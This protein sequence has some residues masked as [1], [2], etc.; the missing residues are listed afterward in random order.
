MLYGA[1]SVLYFRGVFDGAPE[2]VNDEPVV[3]AEEPAVAATGR[4]RP[5]RGRAASGPSRSAGTTHDDA[6]GDDRAR[7]LQ[8]GSEGGEAQLAANVIE[9]VFDAAMNRIRR[10]LVLVEGDEPVQGRL[11]FGV[12]IEPTGHVGAVNLGGPAVVTRGEAGDC[13]RTTARSLVFPAFD[14]PAMVT[15]YPVT[16]E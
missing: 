11:D 15:H 2:Q 4:A 13:L 10:C 14:G 16:L 1:L 7:E 8:M 12:R 9:N 3:A 6:L 5:R